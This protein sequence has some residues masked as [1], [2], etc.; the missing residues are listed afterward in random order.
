MLK[1]RRLLLRHLQRL[2]RRESRCLT[3]IYNLPHSL[4]RLEE[5][6]IA[7]EAGHFDQVSAS[8]MA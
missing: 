4:D 5:S 1:E 6:I 2:T 7:L 3:Y 8:V